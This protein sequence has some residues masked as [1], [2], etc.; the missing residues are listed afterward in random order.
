MAEA[1]AFREIQ[2]SGSRRR[3]LDSLGEL[4][5]FFEV[6]FREFSEKLPKKNFSQK[7]SILKST[8]FF[9]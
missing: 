6:R 3:R 5:L 9:A 8:L 1:Y 2:L 4:F 7:N